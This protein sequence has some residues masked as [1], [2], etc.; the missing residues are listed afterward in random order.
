MGW[1]EGGMRRRRLSE[2]RRGSEEGR[3]WRGGRGADEASPG[4]ILVLR[5]NL[6]S[7]RDIGGVAEV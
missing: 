3:W 1:E 7:I 2:G 4:W 5:M 6:M